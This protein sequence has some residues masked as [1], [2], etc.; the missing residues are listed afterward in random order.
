MNI[1][2]CCKLSDI[3]AGAQLDTTLDEVNDNNLRHRQSAHDAF[4]NVDLTNLE[5]TFRKPRGAAG[6]S[7]ES[8]EKWS[9]QCS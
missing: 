4:A 7:A 9:P 5:C 8:T 3:G 2:D 6:H 1:D